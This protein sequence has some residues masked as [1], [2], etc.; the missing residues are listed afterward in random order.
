VRPPPA[1]LIG[2]AAGG[3]LAAAGL[4][5]LKSHRFRHGSKVE[6]CAVHLRN[7]YRLSEARR[8]AFG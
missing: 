3:F 4:V 7:L 6:R 8:T 1:L 2:L 5:V